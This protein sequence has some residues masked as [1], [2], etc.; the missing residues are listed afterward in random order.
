MLLDPCCSS[1]KVYSISIVLFN[2][3]CNSEDVGIEN[4]VVSRESYAID[5][6][7]IRAFAYLNATFIRISLSRFIERH[8]NDRCTIVTTK[9]CTTHKLILSVLERD[10]VHDSF[11]LQAAKSRFDDRPFR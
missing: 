4:D 11:T 7:A 6:N 5:Q 1:N 9:L 8:H 3:G 2:T 10:R